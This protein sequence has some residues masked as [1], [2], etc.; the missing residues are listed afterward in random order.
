MLSLDTGI[1]CIKQAESWRGATNNLYHCFRLL[2]GTTSRGNT[3][4]PSC[5]RCGWCKP[6]PVCVCVRGEQRGGSRCLQTEE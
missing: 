1:R 6:A 5:C 4:Q 2:A 3:A